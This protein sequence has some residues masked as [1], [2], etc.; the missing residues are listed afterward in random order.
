M[1][2][3]K[4]LRELLPK[5]DNKVLFDR[6]KYR[7]VPQSAGCYV[8]TNFSE[9]ALYIGKTSDLHRRFQ[10]HLDDSQ[11]TGLT[12]EGRAFWFFYLQCEDDNLDL[13]ENS[14]LNDYEIRNGQKPILNKMGTPRS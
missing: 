12:P 10:E 1:K 4:N 11:K 14:W 9:D 8:L 7:S 5:P 13:L 6:S 2:N 3:M